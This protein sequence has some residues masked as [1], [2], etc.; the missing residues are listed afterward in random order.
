MKQPETR[1]I[2][3]VHVNLRA[4]NNEIFHFSPAADNHASRYQLLPRCFRD[5]FLITPLPVLCGGKKKK[6][7][8]RKA[9]ALPR[10]PSSSAAQETTIN[11]V[12]SKR[13]LAKK[14]A[15]EYQ[16]KKKN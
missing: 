7:P 5:D 14:S 9:A 10:D 1:S 13:V 16:K 12:T 8:Q 4:C 6:K 15:Q 2:A 3:D 11:V